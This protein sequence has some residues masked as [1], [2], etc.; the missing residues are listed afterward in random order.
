MVVGIQLVMTGL[1][2]EV[3]SRVYF[4]THDI[5][6]YTVEETWF[7]DETEAEASDKG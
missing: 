3:I 6:I 4:R 2:A 7:H 5:R 1:L